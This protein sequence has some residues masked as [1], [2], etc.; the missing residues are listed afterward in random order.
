[1]IGLLQKGNISSR[2]GFDFNN[3]LSLKSNRDQVVQEWYERARGFVKQSKTSQTE[4]SPISQIKEVFRE[5]YLS[6]Q[7][8]LSIYLSILCSQI[9]SFPDRLIKRTQTTRID[10]DFVCPPSSPNTNGNQTDSNLII[11]PHVFDDGDFYHQILREYIE[12]KTSSITDPEQIS[13]SV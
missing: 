13:K 7:L 1:M 10:Y 5:V 4:Q 9:M 12:R 6:F 11:N 2:I 8:V 3:F